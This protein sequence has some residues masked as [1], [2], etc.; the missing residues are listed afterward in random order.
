MD[1]NGIFIYRKSNIFV[2]KIFNSKEILSTGTCTREGDDIEKPQY[3]ALMFMEDISMNTM[4][5]IPHY[6]S[7]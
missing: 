5:E 7:G 3:S 4:F 2:A 6:V 1:C